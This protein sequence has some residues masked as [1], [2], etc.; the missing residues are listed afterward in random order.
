MQSPKPEFTDLQ[1]RFAGTIRD[2]EHVAT[3]E[4]VEERRMKIY[5]ELFYN[6]VAGFVNSGFPVLKSLSDEAYWQQLIRDFLIEHRCQTPYFLEIA[7]EFV[8]YVSEVREPRSEDLPFLAALAHYEWAELALD[9]AEDP[10]DL[11]TVNPEGDLLSGHPVQSPLAWSLMYEYPVHHIS[12]SFIPEAKSEVPTCLV[13][14]RNNRD[15]VKFMEIN[16]LTARLLH[17]LAEDTDLSGRDALLQIAAEMA[18]PDP[19]VIVQGGLS[20]LEQLRQTEI[21]LGTNNN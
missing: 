8:T 14:Y 13:V 2:P 4:D 7:Q 3:L 5:R 11:S 6:N 16:P 1:Y 18:H 9:T 17:L 19:E 10:D 15:Q 20:I 12:E 21:I